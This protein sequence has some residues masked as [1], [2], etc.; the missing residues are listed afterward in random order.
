M[1]ALWTFSVCI[2]SL[3]EF[4]TSYSTRLFGLRDIKLNKWVDKFVAF[5]R[6]KINA[7]KLMRTSLPKNCVL[8]TVTCNREGF[9]GSKAWIKQ[10]QKYYI[11]SRHTH[12]TQVWEYKLCA[13]LPNIIN[14]TPIFHNFPQKEKEKKLYK[15]WFASF[16]FVRWE[17]SFHF[18][19]NCKGFSSWILLG[20]HL[21]K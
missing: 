1:V 7:K 9:V 5:L 8:S 17:S 6:C 2:K 15:M 19:Y 13:T 4:R 18:N 16:P 14:F 11:A 3:S 20:F 12:K 21:W 10:K